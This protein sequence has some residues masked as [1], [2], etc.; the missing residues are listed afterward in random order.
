MLYE[1]STPSIHY[2]TDMK[3]VIQIILLLRL[4]IGGLSKAYKCGNVGNGALSSCQSNPN[5]R[6]VKPDDGKSY[7]LSL[8]SQNTWWPAEKNEW[9]KC[10]DVCK[11]CKSLPEIDNNGENIWPGS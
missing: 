7:K 2:S 10:N 1:L 8:H 11:V 4:V 6:I 9:V 5:I 3:T